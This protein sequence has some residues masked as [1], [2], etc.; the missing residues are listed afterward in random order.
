MIFYK[1]KDRQT[2]MV[3]F[4]AHDGSASDAVRTLCELSH[5]GLGIISIRESYDDQGYLYEMQNG[6]VFIVTGVS[7]C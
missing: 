3:A 5:N 2:G 7:F 1:I 6:H 4:I